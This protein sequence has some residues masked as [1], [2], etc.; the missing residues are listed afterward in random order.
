MPR[1]KATEDALPTT[2]RLLEAAEREFAEK[3]FEAAR[4][5]DIAERI[6]IRRPSLLYHF[7]SKQAL[8]EAVVKTALLRLGEALVLEM[9]G[10]DPFVDRFHRAVDRF[11]TF[12]EERPM[13][14]KLLLREVLD[15]RG[16]G[17]AILLEVG[18]P[19]VERVES[20]MRD[21][22]RGVVPDDLPIR[23]ALMAIVSS[24]MLRVSA[25]PLAEP[26]WGPKDRTREVARAMFLAR[27]PEDA[28][29]SVKRTNRRP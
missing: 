23:A 14:A 13:I 22:G 19:V 8:Y 15:A 4:L 16:P 3:G 21:D 28:T 12:V 29:L 20:F 18:I 7:G 24:A 10:P 1:P 5:S 26:F 2:E 25:G 27:K 11:G 6:G 9:A 17:H